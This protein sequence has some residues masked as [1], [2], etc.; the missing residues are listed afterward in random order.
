[1]GDQVQSVEETWETIGSDE[2][3]KIY[4][5]SKWHNFGGYVGRLL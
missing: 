5:H 1:M 3:R 2:I 4:A